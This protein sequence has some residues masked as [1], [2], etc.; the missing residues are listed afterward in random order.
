LKN[1][2]M[3]YA[4]VC[5]GIEAPSLA[6]HGLGWSPVWFSEIENFPAAVL[7]HHY[8]AVPNLGDM[9]MLHENETYKNEPIDLLCGGT[10]CQSFSFAGLRKGLD[11]E[12]ATL[13]CTLFGFLEKNVRPGLYG[14]T[15]PEF[16]PAP[17]D[18]TL[19]QFWADSRA[20]ILLS[21][22]TDGETPESLKESPTPTALP[23]QLLTLNTSEYR[24]GAAVSSL[25]DILETGTV[26]QRYYLTPLAC[27][28]ILRRAEKRG[29]ELPT[30][31]R[32]ALEAVARQPDQ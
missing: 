4:T 19:Q 3:K 13:H 20:G 1:E 6:W 23:G 10:P 11:D 22:G 26:P 31:L 7:K 18:A 15:F 8:P 28:G 9:T 5:S 12:T 30:E 17:A 21:P 24:S 25:S 2:T 16:C 32:L 29:K 27:R 14:K